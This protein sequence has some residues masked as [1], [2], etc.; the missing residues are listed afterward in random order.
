MLASETAA[1]PAATTQ[2]TPSTRLYYTIRAEGG[3]LAA[4]H[5]ADGPPITTTASPESATRFVDIVTAGRRAAALQQLGWR[6]LRVIA[7]YLPSAR[8]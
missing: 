8:P 2:P 5:A 7:I 1:Y 3:F 4:S 6:D